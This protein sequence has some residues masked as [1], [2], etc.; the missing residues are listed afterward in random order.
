MTREYFELVREHGESFFGCDK[1]CIN[2]CTDLTKYNLYTI[3]NCL[4]TC[5]CEDGVL[6]I[7]VGQ[8]DPNKV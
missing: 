2:N 5:H 1:N 6:D 4:N 7:S 3:E 8:F